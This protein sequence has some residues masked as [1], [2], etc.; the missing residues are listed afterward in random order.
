[1]VLIPKGNFLA[2]FCAQG[3]QSYHFYA[4]LLLKRK[5]SSLK[6]KSMN[7]LFINA[8]VR[9]ESRTL[10]LAKD[11]LNKMQGEITEIHLA[12]E[13]LA[14][15]DRVTLEKR[16][17]LLKSKDMDDPLFQYAKQF[18]QA[19]EIVIAAP[20]WDLSFPSILKIY[21]EQITVAGITFEYRNGCPTGL[22]KAKRLVYVTTAG[23]EIFC[24]FGYAYIKAI[25]NNFFGIQDTVAYRATN[26][27]VLGIS[28]D[29]LLQKATISTVQ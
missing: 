21:L 27:D 2:I 14:P 23:G 18:A 1:L 8:C 12:N 4:I 20:F 3:L 16:E 13:N 25:A 6:G 15:L 5:L 11:I 24:D 26:L 9:K 28:A 29:E 17:R 7:I 22:C 19:D 10:V